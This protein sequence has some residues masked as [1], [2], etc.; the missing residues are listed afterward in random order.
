MHSCPANA[1]ALYS[2][3]C[4]WS[5][6]GDAS[7]NFAVD[8]TSSTAGREPGVPGS[9]YLKEMQVTDTPIVAD[10]LVMLGICIVSRLV[11]YI[12][13]LYWRRPVTTS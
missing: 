7:S 11:A 4:S 6:A 12:V 13:L 2:E 10:V 1:T 5:V 3:Y 9:V 8:P